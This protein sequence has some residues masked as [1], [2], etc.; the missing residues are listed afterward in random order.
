MSYNV[1][2]TKE[3]MSI[4]CWRPTIAHTAHVNQIEIST[5]ITKHVGD[6]RTKEW[7]VVSIRFKL[8]L[9]DSVSERD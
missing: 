4:R 7:L 3:Q 2:N 9:D 8:T 6:D 5:F 1:M